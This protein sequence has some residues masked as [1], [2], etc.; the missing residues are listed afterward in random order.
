METKVIPAKKYFCVTRTAS[1]EK[2]PKVAMEEADAI[3]EEAKAAKA[4]LS[5]PMEFIYFGASNDKEAPFSM[6]I[7]MPVS[8]DVK[9][10]KGKYFTKQLGEFKC[11]SYIHKGSFSD[12]KNV[13]EQLFMEL[14]KKNYTHTPQVREVYLEWHSMDSPDNQVEIQIGIE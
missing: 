3:V 6:E 2:I 1:L 11:M 12:I 5:G 14:K 10:A 13:Y 8:E 7:A 9:G 4:V